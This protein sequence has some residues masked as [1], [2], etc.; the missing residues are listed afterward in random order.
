MISF[1][2]LKPPTRQ[3]VEAPM[4]SALER[5]RAENSLLHTHLSLTICFCWLSRARLH[6]LHSLGRGFAKHLAGNIYPLLGMLPFVH[7]LKIP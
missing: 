7:F 2:P 4:R 6:L 5:S 3:P 1:S